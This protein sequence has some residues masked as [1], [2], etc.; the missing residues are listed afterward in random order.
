MIC[1]NYWAVLYN[2]PSLT[3]SLHSVWS[4]AL[5]TQL[6]VQET[7]LNVTFFCDHFDAEHYYILYCVGICVGIIRRH[8]NSKCDTYCVCKVSRPVNEKKKDL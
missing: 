3:C 5:M 1:K 7:R 6:L 2:Y 4:L 8:K